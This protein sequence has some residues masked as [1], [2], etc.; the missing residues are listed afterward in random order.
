MTTDTTPATKFLDVL[1][2]RGGKRQSLEWQP[3][4]T[5]FEHGEGFVVLTS[6]RDRT[7]YCI[8][9]YPGESTLLGFVFSKVGG[10]GT[11]KGRTSYVLT[12]TRNGNDAKCDCRSFPKNGYCRHADALETLFLNKWLEG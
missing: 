12:C 7:S 3:H 8:T 5:D 1:P 11:D 6:D 10:K 2:I 9:Q 4:S